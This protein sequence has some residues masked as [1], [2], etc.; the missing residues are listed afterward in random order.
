MADD[1]EMLDSIEFEWQIKNMG[2]RE[3]LEFNA[4]QAYQIK[5]E[6]Y[7]IKKDIQSNKKRS[8]ANRIAIIVIIVTLILLGIFDPS[9]FRVL[10]LGWLLPLS[11]LLMA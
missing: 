10:A 5:S 11:I 1:K 7:Y 4:R 2:E 3:L 6:M 9:L 8:W